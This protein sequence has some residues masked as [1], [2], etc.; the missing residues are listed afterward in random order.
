LVVVGL[1]IFAAAVFWLPR[2]IVYRIDHGRLT[3]DYG[4]E[5]LESSRGLSL[6][7]IR[8]AEPV[9]LRGGRRVMGTNLP[10][11]CTGRFRY[12][13]LG[14]VW[15]AGDC[16]GQGVLI[17][18]VGDG[19]PW[20]VSPSDTGVFLEALETGRWYRG[21]IVPSDPGGGFV[22]V[23]LA[24]LVPLL[25]AAT[26]PV[27]FFA[28]PKRLSYRVVSGGIE[29]STLLRRRR[30]DTIGAAARRHRPK[31]GLRLWGSG[32]P[33][34]FTGWFLVDG[35]RC[36]VY[37][38]GFDDGVLI[39]SPQLRLFLSPSDPAAFVSALVSVAGVRGD[40]TRGS[41]E[42]TGTA[43]SSPA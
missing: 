6:D 9:V 25:L 37:A 41:G 14:E 38:T 19:R 15:Q 22:L 20:L 30:F 3:V 12:R 35:K 1:S 28:A 39:E 31:P 2:A 13:E 36:R 32:M 27:V 34:Y 42:S 16:S 8:S 4:M 33:G 21:E 26:V 7:Q 43:R 11:Y 17:R 40:G 29:V 10:G 24:M 23:R 18:T 5:W